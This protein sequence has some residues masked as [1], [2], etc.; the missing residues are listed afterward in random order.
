VW[1]GGHQAIGFRD[2]DGSREHFS[3]FR[4]E[5]LQRAGWT[6]DPIESARTLPRVDRS[7]L[8]LGPPTGKQVRDI[9]S[10]VRP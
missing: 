8:E 1:H 5:D 4:V 9:M 6:I 10:K 7:A 2:D 3:L